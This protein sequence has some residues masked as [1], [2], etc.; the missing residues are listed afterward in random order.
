ME[1]KLKKLNIQQAPNTTLVQ[2][3][4]PT[5]LHKKTKLVLKS[6]KITWNE[7]IVAAMRQICAEAGLEEE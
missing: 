2:A 6:R 3:K 4:V 7:L 1:L 5:N